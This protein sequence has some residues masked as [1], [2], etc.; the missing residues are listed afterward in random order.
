MHNQLTA[1]RFTQ[2]GLSNK[3]AV[4]WLVSPLDDQSKGC[5]VHFYHRPCRMNPIFFFF[6]QLCMK[7]VYTYAVTKWQ[8]TS[9]AAVTTVSWL[10]YLLVYWLIHP[11]VYKTSYFCHL[12]WHLYNQSRILWY[13][14]KPLL[15][16]HRY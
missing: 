9:A 4:A 3:H 16:P 8:Q 14:M 6:T 7:L 2:V 5:R 11:G 12:H 15:N 10:Y 1:L 13:L